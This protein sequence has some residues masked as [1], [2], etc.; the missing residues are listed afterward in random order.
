MKKFFE[1][2]F[3]FIFGIMLGMIFTTTTAYAA[4]C[5]WARDVGFESSTGLKS[6]N[7]QDAVDELVKSKQCPTT[8]SQENN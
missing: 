5:V 8:E 7:V 2:H 6:T 3:Q 4:Y 1:K